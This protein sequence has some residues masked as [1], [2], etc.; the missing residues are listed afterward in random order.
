MNPAV[1][2]SGVLLAA[3]NRRDP[4]HGQCRDLLTTR[5]WFITIPVLCVTEIA[6]L[7]ARDSDA[8]SEA[9]FLRS[10]AS[11]EV[12][13]PSPEDWSRMAEL[14]LKYADFPLGTVDASVI[15][16]AERLNARTIFTLDRRHFGA[17]RPAHIE[18]F[19]L[20]P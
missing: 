5:S 18:A 19:E 11:S 12:E 16:L 7:L 13:Q 10:L 6:Q 4:Y 1:M 2:D 20:L 15:A 3:M 9:A 8:A 17:V 14:V